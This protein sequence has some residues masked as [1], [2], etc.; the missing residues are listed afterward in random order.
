[1][2]GLS[3]AMELGME[4]AQ[5]HGQLHRRP[6]GYWTPPAEPMRPGKRGPWEDQRHVGTQTVDA[7]VRRGLLER[8]G[9]WAG[10]SQRC[11]TILG[12]GE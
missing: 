7:L 4:L 12:H 6:G 2:T 9:R 8:E 1:M 3:D 5:E 11:A 10:G